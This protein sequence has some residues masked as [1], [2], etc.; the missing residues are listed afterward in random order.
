[1]IEPLRELVELDRVVGARSREELRRLDLLG[2]TRQRPPPRVELDH[3]ALVVPEV[4]KQPPQPLRAAAVPV[5]DDE[6]AGADPRRAGCARERVRFRQRMPP[7]LARRG[8]EICVDIE[9]ARAWD[10]AGEVQLASAGG[11]PELPAAVDELITHDVD[12][13]RDLHGV[14]TIH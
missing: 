9:E 2:A 7:T 5:G 8:R 12:R 11:V 14:R 4:A 6:D 10:V 1:M 13:M 3:A